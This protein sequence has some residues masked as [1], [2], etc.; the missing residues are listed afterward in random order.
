MVHG[1]LRHLLNG[2]TDLRRHLHSFL[3]FSDV[4]L[5]LGISACPWPGSRK[6]SFAFAFPPS[7][8]NDLL[9]LWP[10]KSFAEAEESVECCWGTAELLPWLL[11]TQG[12][13]TRFSYSPASHRLSPDFPTIFFCLQR[14]DSAFLLCRRAGRYCC[15]PNLRASSRT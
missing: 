10:T 5:H 3:Q 15:S 8:P 9:L 2:N 4:D 6:Q 7:V 13:T 1:L 12:R 14:G 11:D